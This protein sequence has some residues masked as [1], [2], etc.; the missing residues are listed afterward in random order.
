M[1]YEGLKRAAVVCGGPK[2]IDIYTY[3][4]INARSRHG[5]FETLGVLFV[6]LAHISSNLRS[7]CSTASGEDS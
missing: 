7:K 2:P 3:K 4:H 1:A 5:Q 6:G